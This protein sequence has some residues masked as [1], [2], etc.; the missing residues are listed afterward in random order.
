MEGN[1]QGP[2]GPGWL[3]P[4]RIR[5]A[6]IRTRAWSERSGHLNGQGVYGCGRRRSDP[7]TAQLGG[8]AFTGTRRRLFRPVTNCQHFPGG[9]AL[10]ARA[11]WEGGPSCVPAA[12]IVAAGGALFIRRSVSNDRSGAAPA[13]Q[14][15][16]AAA[17]RRAEDERRYSRGHA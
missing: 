17:V 14:R 16:V 13:G 8:E 12:G 9:Q 7:N 2:A 1:R 11:N 3:V 6:P 4:G 15:A 10:T 5:H